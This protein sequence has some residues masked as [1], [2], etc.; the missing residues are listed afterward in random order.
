MSTPCAAASSTDRGCSTPAPASA[1]SSI[2][3]CRSAVSRRASGTTRGSA[4]NTAGHVG[5]DLA[6]PDPQP[7][8]D[9]HR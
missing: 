1:I 9:G 5:E 2:S 7:G 4:V 8:G 6:L 3:S